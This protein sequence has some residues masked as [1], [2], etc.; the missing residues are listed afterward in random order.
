M[1]RPGCPLTD[2][3]ENL[4]RSRKSAKNMKAAISTMVAPVGVFSQ[5]DAIRPEMP[6]NIDIATDT[7]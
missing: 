5:Y 7:K 4:F 1:Y 3:C 2:Q 6:E